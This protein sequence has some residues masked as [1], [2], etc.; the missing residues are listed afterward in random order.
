M[1]PTRTQIQDIVNIYLEI[2]SQ[3]EQL[4]KAIHRMSHTSYEPVMEIADWVLD[5]LKI[6]Y[7]A[8]HEDVCY[9]LFDA[10]WAYQNREEF[11]AMHKKG[12]T[13]TWPLKGEEDWEWSID[14]WGNDINTLKELLLVQDLIS[15]E[16]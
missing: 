10:W 3:Q 15:N 1:K 8:I 14:V 4:S 11:R 2:D 6:L 16:E 12:Y 9:W 7:P 13:C 5:V